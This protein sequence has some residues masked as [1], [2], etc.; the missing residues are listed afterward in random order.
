MDY[1]LTRGFARDVRGAVAVAELVAGALS[2]YDLD[3]AAD[4]LR[5]ARAEQLPPDLHAAYSQLIV[6]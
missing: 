6:N 2:R 1:A 5:S 4:V 3:A